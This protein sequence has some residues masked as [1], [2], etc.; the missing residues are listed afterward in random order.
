[1]IVTMVASANGLGHA[2]RVL[3]VALKWSNFCTINVLLTQRQ[4]T[5]LRDEFSLENDSFSLIEIP[6]IGLQGPDCDLTSFGHEEVPVSVSMTLGKSDLVISDNALWPR[7]YTDNFI[8]MGH[9][10]WVDYYQQLLNSGKR[11]SKSYQ[12][13][14]E[15]EIT[16]LDSVEK[17][18]LLEPFAFGSL[19]NIPRQIKF[20]MPRYFES[21]KKKLVIQNLGIIAV[22]TT[23]HN[24]I[25]KIA[26][27]QSYSNLDLIKLETFQLQFLPYIPRVVLGRP[28]LG[29][30]RD[31]TEHQISFLP[32]SYQDLELKNNVKVLETYSTIDKDLKGA[33]LPNTNILSSDSEWL[34][35]LDQ[36]MSL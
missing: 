9:F 25:D 34:V 4:L 26:L 30:I 2:R 6:P 17:G 28:G 7:L 18:F 5:I 29:T 36:L 22:G 20:K 31:C 19:L 12:H 13:F 32:L 1:M 33:M 3:H 11:V 10:T 16:I 27:Q 14:L 23:V 21:I 35:Y 24:S 8:L 15:K